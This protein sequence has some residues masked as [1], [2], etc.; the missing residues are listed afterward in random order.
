MSTATNNAAH[1]R[2]MANGN[3][4]YAPG[5]GLPIVETSFNGNAIDNAA[6]VADALNVKHE[7]GLT[8]RQLAEQRAELL[9][10]LQLLIPHAEHAESCGD[11]DAYNNAVVPTCGCGLDSTVELARAA[12]A[13]AGAK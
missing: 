9:E 12:I 4:V 2:Y 8:P 1:T 13:K 7:T 11:S 5:S 6:L 3:F 10:A